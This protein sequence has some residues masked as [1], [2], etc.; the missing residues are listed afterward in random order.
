[1]EH[2][3]VEGVFAA[4]ASAAT[5]TSGAATMATHH[6]E[7]LAN[8]DA[9]TGEAT[10]TSLSR[11]HGDEDLACTAGAAAHLDE[12]AEVHAGREASFCAV[13]RVATLVINH[14]L[15]FVSEDAVS[16]LDLAELLLSEASLGRTALVTIW[17]P[18][19]AHE[20]V[21]FLIFFGGGIDVLVH[22]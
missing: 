16:L 18:F 2:V 12:L 1:M 9:E 22:A 8:V 5:G 20:F 3:E 11:I 13:V 6:G 19:N 14:L 21:L 4:S 7:Y 17:V 10:K 15:L